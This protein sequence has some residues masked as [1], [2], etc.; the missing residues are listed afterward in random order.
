MEVK[1]NIMVKRH[2]GVKYYVTESQEMNRYGLLYYNTPHM[3]TV[4]LK[5]ATRQEVWV[6]DPAE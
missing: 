1:I 3:K 2:C 4:N 6:F 5:A